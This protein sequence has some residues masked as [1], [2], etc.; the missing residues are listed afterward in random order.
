MLEDI[1]GKPLRETYLVGD[2]LKQDDRVFCYPKSLRDDALE[3]IP[4]IVD[5][6]DLISTIK[7]AHYS[8]IA[9]LTER[10]I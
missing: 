10:E 7:Q 1:S 9:K 4:Y 8:A 2:H 3:R 5:P 6:K